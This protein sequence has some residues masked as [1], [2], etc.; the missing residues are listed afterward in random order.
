MEREMN[1]VILGMLTAGAVII[2]AELLME[3]AG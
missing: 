2:T 1:Y 3:Y